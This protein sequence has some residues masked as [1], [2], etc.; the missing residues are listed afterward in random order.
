MLIPL[1]RPHEPLCRP[2]VPALPEEQLAAQFDVTLE[3]VRALREQVA[4]CRRRVRRVT[5]ALVVGS[6]VHAS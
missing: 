6:E 3:R 4:A 2:N 1:E 5:G